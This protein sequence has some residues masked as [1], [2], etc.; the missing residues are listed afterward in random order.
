MAQPPIESKIMNTAARILIFSASVREGSLNQQLATLAARRLQ[1]SGVAVTQL[2]LADYPLPIYSGDIEAAGM[3]PAEAL[4]LHQYLRS[5]DGVFIAC[6]EYNSALPP[7]LVNTLD[8]ISRVVS[9]GG[10]AAAFGKPVFALG[11]ASPGGFGGYRGLVSLRSML[12]LG[13]SARVLPTMIS[14]PQANEAFDDAGELYN[15]HTRDLL[16]QVLTNLLVACHS[17]VAA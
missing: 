8:W 15:S 2:N 14:V 6:P 17:Q 9:H 3:V 4:V 7:L 13:L 1:E 16:D 11:S 10:I 12:E 5:H